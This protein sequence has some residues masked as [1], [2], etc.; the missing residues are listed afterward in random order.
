MNEAVKLGLALLAAASGGSACAMNMSQQDA[1]QCSVAHA[2]K[3]PS[4]LSESAICAAIGQ[5]AAPV[6]DRAS[7][8]HEALAVRVSVESDSKLVAS[9]TLAGKPLPEQRV[10]TS[11]RALNAGAVAMLAR[12][13]AAEIAAS[14]NPRSGA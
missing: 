7:L 13:I 6:L 12:A 4:N 11:D 14:S 2:E 3:L 8:A 10:A 9:A 1:V 5:A